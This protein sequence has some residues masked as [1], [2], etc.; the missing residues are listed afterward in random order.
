MSW[1]KVSDKLPL[2]PNSCPI[3]SRRSDVFLYS[4]NVLLFEKS[5]HRNGE[6]ITIGCVNVYPN[7]GETTWTDIHGQEI[8]PTHWQ[9]LPEKP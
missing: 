2:T 7:G 3:A 6:D 4:D 1:I 8:H 5:S 9:P